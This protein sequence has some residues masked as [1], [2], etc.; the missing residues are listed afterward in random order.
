V[1]SL[2]FDG[3]RVVDLTTVVAGPYATQLLA[4][5]GADVIK[6]EAPTGDI[7]RD[8]GPHV[9]A[10]M[11]A[12]FLNCNR[13]KRS[14]VLDLAT[15]DGR[16]ALKELCD[17]ADVFV[18]NM[19]PAAAVRCGADAETLRAGHPELVHCSIHGFATE[20]PYRDLP[21]YDDIIQGASGMAGSQEWI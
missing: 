1:P 10:G 7:A 15:A 14:V 12:V 13:G 9:N 18:E 11:G 20:G 19:R 2:P 6:V 17:T 16:R 5:L 8:L 4:D 21:A 3:V